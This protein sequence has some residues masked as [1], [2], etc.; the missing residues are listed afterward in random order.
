MS[1]CFFSVWLAYYLRLNEFIILSEQN[2]IPVIISISLAIPIFVI[3]GLYRTIFR[4]TGLAALLTVF[5]AVLIYGLIY[6]V[7]ITLIGITDVPRT[8]GIIQPILLFLFISISRVIPSI[9]LGG[10]YLT[11]LNKNK[12]KNVL[13][14]GAGK[15]GMQLA[16]MLEKSNEA[17]VIG[18]IDDDEKLHGN[19]INDLMVYSAK[20]INKII[21]Q[22]DISDLLLTIPKLTISK[23]SI[24][25]NIEKKSIH[26][27]VVPLMKDIISGDLN[28]S[29]IKKVDIIDLLGREPINPNKR[30]LA[31]NIK[32]KVVLI[33]GAGGSI[34]SELCRQIIKQKPNKLLLLELN[35][36]SLYKIY[37]ELI[38]KIRNLNLELYLLLHRYKMKK[39]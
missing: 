29:D 27:R 14:Y 35:E 34:G 22:F 31:T 25:N 11:I 8:I 23:K 26:V 17:I 20:N 39:N 18:F 28:I 2:F 13:I 1:V 3:N 10:D 38:L 37:E 4:Y 12:I 32:N 33:T 5:R 15:Q 21:S 16:D 30:L 9:W 36:Y 7:I 6:A 24:V 19:K